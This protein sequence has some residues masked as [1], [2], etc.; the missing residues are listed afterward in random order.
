[1]TLTEIFKKSRSAI[2]FALSL[3]VVEKIAWIVEPTLLGRLIDALIGVFQTREHATFGLPLILWIVAFLV[4][5]GAGSLRRSVDP[6]IYLKI[7]VSIAVHIAESCRIKGDGASK[8]AARTELAREYIHFFQERVPEFIEQV[9]DLVGAMIA[10]AFYDIRISLTCFAVALPMAFVG[11]SYKHNVMRL[12][13]E[14]HD[15]REDLFAVVQ[16]QAIEGIRDFHVKMVKPQLR[17]A[18]WNAFNFGFLRIILLGIFLVVLY[19]VIALD[20]LSTGEIYSVVAY[21]WT[22]IGATE[23]SPDLL[24]SY[25]SL[26]DI[27]NRIR[28]VA[29]NGPAGNNGPSEAGA[30]RNDGRP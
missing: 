7:Y 2:A 25:T 9:F 4:N 24:E 22:F 23:F 28:T 17:I 13:K 30:G 20:R 1:M 14:F 15:H 21:L 5:S 3:A 16:K 11:Y 8:A 27:Q 19:L 10:L 12:Q 18:N 26:K 29:P 6:R